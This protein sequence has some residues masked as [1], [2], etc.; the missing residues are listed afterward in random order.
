MAAI[1]KDRVDSANQHSKGEPIGETR[2]QHLLSFLH[3][4]LFQPE[5]VEPCSDG[6]CPP[7]VYM[8]VGEWLARES[9]VRTQSACFQWEVT[10]RWY[11]AIGIEADTDAS[12]PANYDNL[13]DYPECGSSLFDE[14]H[15][16]YRISSLPRACVLACWRV[17]RTV[18]SSALL[19]ECSRYCAAHR[20]LSVCMIRLALTII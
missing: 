6:R 12:N 8:Y 3:C 7:T 2:N 9:L 11:A 20:G 14:G 1:K 19:A 18:C 4:N 17:P 16:A 5:E 10:Q 13:P 15:A